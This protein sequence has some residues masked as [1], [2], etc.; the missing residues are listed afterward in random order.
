MLM[1]PTDVG[2]C[3]RS[4]QEICRKDEDD[5]LGLLLNSHFVFRHLTW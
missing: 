5:S 2:S 4:R 3:H 1:S